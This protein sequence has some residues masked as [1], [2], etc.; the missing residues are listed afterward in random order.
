M[1]L[2]KTYKNLLGRVNFF[3]VNTIRTLQGDLHHP[4]ISKLL[5]GDPIF[6]AYLLGTGKPTGYVNSYAKNIVYLNCCV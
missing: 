6:S 1:P 5:A 2:I 3:A 4:S